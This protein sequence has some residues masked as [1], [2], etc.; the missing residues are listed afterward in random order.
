MEEDDMAIRMKGIHFSEGLD[1]IQSQLLFR[2]PAVINVI[3]SLS[4]SLVHCLAF[5]FHCQVK[6][7]SFAVFC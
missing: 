4:S 7:S 2:W 3:E 6:V 5:G 1:S